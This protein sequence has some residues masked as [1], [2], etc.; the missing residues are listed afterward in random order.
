MS[1]GD[2]SDY[3]HNY[4]KCAA[5]ERDRLRVV[6]EGLVK[7]LQRCRVLNHTCGEREHCAMCI[8]ITEA[9]DEARAARAEGIK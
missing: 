5:A 4:T 3:E 6:N 1:I 9:L 7:A 2:T 8:G